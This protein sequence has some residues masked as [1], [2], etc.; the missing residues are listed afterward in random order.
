VKKWHEETAQDE[1]PIISSRIRFARN[2]KNYPFS[3]AISEK[4]SQDLISEVKNSLLNDRSA[5]SK[6]LKYID[7]TS[8]SD[9]EKLSL[10]ERHAISRDFIQTR[11][12]RGLILKNDEK[13]GVMINEEDH[14]RL[15]TIFAGDKI[16]EAYELANL[17]DDLMEET[18]EYAFD[19]ELGYL[20]TC[21]TNV[22]TGLR[23]SYMIHLPILTSSPQLGILTN[24]IAKF[25]MT[26]RG[27]FG[28]GTTPA[29]NIFQISNQ[30]TIGRREEDIIKSL[31]TITNQVIE[32]E[33]IVLRKTLE[34]KGLELS[35]KVNRSY[36]IIK[37]A[38][39]ISSKEAVDLL[40]DVRLG[41]MS[42]LIDSPK[43]ET[44][45]YKIMMNIRDAALQ[46]NLSEN[47][48]G[49]KRDAARADYLREV[50]N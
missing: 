2:L 8:L 21:P 50:F 22:G 32:S 33:Q 7:I 28:E 47:D 45:I 24:S 42:G 25:G 39:K 35:D 41:F 4:Q 23:A 19:R 13:I 10:M 49:I 11:R 12:E 18:L 16:D 1:S 37:N 30:T 38:R 20:T 29:G 6:E 17:V 27:I 5:L 9:L 26:I 44:S 15:Q 43:P 46:S 40:S 14:V 31:K 3:T 48:D 34:Q 36:G